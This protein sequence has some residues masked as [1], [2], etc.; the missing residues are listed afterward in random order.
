MGPSPQSGIG[1]SQQLRTSSQGSLSSQFIQHVPPHTQFQQ[2]AHT[3]PSG[4]A[5]QKSHADVPS[6]QVLM[7]Q[8]GHSNYSPIQSQWHV[9]QQPQFTTKP[10]N[11][12]PG[13][14]SS[15]VPDPLNQGHHNQTAVHG[16]THQQQQ[17]QQQN[18]T[19]HPFGPEPSH[20]N[21]I[22]PLTSPSLQPSHY[23][24]TGQAYPVLNDTGSLPSGTGP[25]YQS[26]FAQSHQGIPDGNRGYPISQPLP[27]QAAPASQ[28]LLR[29]SS[30]NIPSPYGQMPLP[31]QGTYTA[32]SHYMGF[33]PAQ[34]SPD[35]VFPTSNQSLPVTTVPVSNPSFNTQPVT[36]TVE[37]YGMPFV[38]ANSQ[39]GGV[40]LPGSTWSAPLQ[41][42]NVAAIHV[43]SV[44]HEIN[45][46]TSASPQGPLHHNYQ[47]FQSQPNQ[48][49]ALVH[50]WTT[51]PG[52]VPSLS[53]MSDP[54]FVS[55]PWS[56]G[57]PPPAAGMIQ[58]TP[59]GGPVGYGR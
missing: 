48:T 39:L 10:V 11:N 59:Y 37:H 18:L 43:P 19:Q 40:N 8:V 14:I 44:N 4:V 17:Q 23:S 13:I 26:H 45:A 20:Q 30:Q 1:L 52:V 28:P 50:E 47:A 12:Q 55:G 22:R 54:Q 5:V 53:A 41:S 15:P 31:Q 7:E 25:S 34:T 38:P 42:E 35:G 58:P 21:P 9:G 57:I 33:N 56:S 27:Q 36:T 2:G 16:Y 32:N 46:N 51:S 3:V 49:V 6:A 29:S 24:I